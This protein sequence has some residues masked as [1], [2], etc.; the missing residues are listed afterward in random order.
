MSRKWSDTL[1]D[2]SV[3][4][5]HILQVICDWVDTTVMVTVC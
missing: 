2:V 3:R 1:S 5:G 4:Y